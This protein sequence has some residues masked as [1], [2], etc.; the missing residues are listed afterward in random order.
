MLYM[1][2]ADATSLAFCTAG[3]RI[4][5]LIS[6]EHNECRLEDE[7]WTVSSLV[8]T[9]P[10]AAYYYDLRTGDFNSQ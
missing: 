4:T 6:F 8:F 1:E 7:H 3:G 5:D 10:R 9:V 2:L